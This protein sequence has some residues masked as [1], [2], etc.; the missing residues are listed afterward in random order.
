VRYVEVL[1]RVIAEINNQKTIKRR[2]GGRKDK[3][4]RMARKKT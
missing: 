3:S 2:Q 1:H 4:E